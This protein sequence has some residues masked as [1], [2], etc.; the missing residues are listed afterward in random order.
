MNDKQQQG[1]IEDIPEALRDSPVSPT[2]SSLN[3]KLLM[4]GVSGLII[5]ILGTLGIMRLVSSPSQT[6]PNTVAVEPTPSPSPTPEMVENI[7]GHLPYEEADPDQLKAVTNDGRIKLR[8]KAADSFLKMQRDARAN[9]IILTPISGFRTVEQQEYLFFE[10]KRQRNQ[11][12]R[13]RAE[14]SAPPKYSEHHTGYAIDI[15]DGQVPATNLTENFE[16]TPAFRWLEN[17]AAKYSFELSFP[18]NNP[19]GISY[20]PWHW[21]YVGDADSLKTFYEAQQLQNK[22]SSEENIVN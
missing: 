21:R 5:I 1:S 2:S 14:V 19:Q 9:G 10:I 3:P 20:E 12:T 6:N 11:D 7:L 13:K 16:Q 4:V 18:R 15:G 17:N 22:S 8:K